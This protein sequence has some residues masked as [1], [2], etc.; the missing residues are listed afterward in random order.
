MP[1][2]KKTSDQ[3]AP[4]QVT[5]SPVTAEKSAKPAARRPRT[6]RAAKP[7]AAAT[8]RPVKAVASRAAKTAASARP[9]RLDFNKRVLETAIEPNR[10]LLDQVK[11]LSI[12]YTNLDEF[13][14]VRVANI[15]KQYKTGSGSSGPDKM[16]PARQLTEIRK[17]ALALIDVAAA[18]W[19][20][21]LLRQVFGSLLMI[22]F[23][24]MLRERFSRGSR[25]RFIRFS[26]LRRS[27][28][29]ILS[30]E[31]RMSLSIS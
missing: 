10:P 14:M 5:E 9:K 7:A 15:F 20:E 12:F 29:D 2:S 28:R 18:H 4:A 1:V 23:L 16:T 30:R 25:R 24:L 13:F 21:K 6:R 11:F 3:N 17:K 22:S 27:T 26:R 8:S 19:T 31:S